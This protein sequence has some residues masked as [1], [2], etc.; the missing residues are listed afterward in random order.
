MIG[1]VRLEIFWGMYLWGQGRR[2]PEAERSIWPLLQKCVCDFNRV[3]T[4]ILE[5]LM[6]L[7][8]L[9]FIKAKHKGMAGFPA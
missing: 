3:E 7:L 5:N 1:G 6:K 2:K 8:G 9:H 4:A